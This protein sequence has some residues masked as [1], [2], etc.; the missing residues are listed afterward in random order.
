MKVVATKFSS[1]AFLKDGDDEMQ[2]YCSN[3]ASQYQWINPYVD[4]TKTYTMEVA[5]CN[6]NNGSKFKACLLSITD[7]NG[8]KVMNS[9]NFNS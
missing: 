5:V 7:S 2:L 8:N 6:W 4:D 3:A 9:L 1:N